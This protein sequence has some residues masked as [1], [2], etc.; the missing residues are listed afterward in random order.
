M[1][2]DINGS[3]K[4]MDVRD[5]AVGSIAAANKGGIG[6]GYILSNEA[7]TLKKLSNL[8]QKELGCQP[9]KFFL[10]IKMAEKIAKKMEKKAAKTGQMPMMTTFSVYNLKRNNKF[11]YSKAERELGYKTCPIEETLS[12]EAKWLKENGKI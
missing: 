10:P 4:L 8:L 6:E 2:I 9:I 1:P 5:L 7:I 3:F 11:D 12:D